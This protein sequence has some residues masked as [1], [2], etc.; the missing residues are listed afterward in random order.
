MIKELVLTYNEECSA[1]GVWV[2]VRVLSGLRR[3]SR[4]I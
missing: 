4:A 1:L 2:G 3:W